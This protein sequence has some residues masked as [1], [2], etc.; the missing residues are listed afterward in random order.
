[1]NNLYNIT[2]NGT[3]IGTSELE[4]ADV[5]M[6]VVLGELKCI[7]QEFGYDYLKELCKDNQIELACD[8]PE[9]KMIS[10]MSISELKITNDNGVEIKGEGNQITG[11]DNEEYEISIFGIPYPFYEGEF[12][13][14][15]QEYEN[16][17]SEE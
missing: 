3:L 1:M 15:V 14:H 17:F 5:P 11:M 6:G 9:A 10:I 8:Y 12:P 4:K 16:I 13:Q 2:L 7:D